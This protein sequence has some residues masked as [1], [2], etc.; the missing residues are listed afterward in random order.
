MTDIAGRLVCTPGAAL[1]QAL[2]STRRAWA[3]VAAPGRAAGDLPAL[4]ASL[5]ALCGGAH[6][7]AA[8]LAVRAAR[9]DPQAP[10]TTQHEAL[11]QDTLR[12]HLRR[13]WLDAADRAEG[14]A[15]A[16]PRVL[17]TCPLLRQPA[18]VDDAA[19]QRWLVAH[20]FGQDAAAWLEAWA[21]EA[22]PTA[23]LW[24]TEGRTWPARALAALHHRLDGWSLPVQA[25]PVQDLAAAAPAL[26]AQLQADPDFALQPLWQGR[27][28]ETGPWT[29]SAE[30]AL[31]PNRAEEFAPAWMRAAARVA[32][33]ARLMAPDDPQAL[34]AGSVALEAGLG[35]A[36]CE[37]ARG[38]LI[39]VVQ[40]DGQDRVRACHVLAPTEWN[41][42][43]AGGL[44]RAL[45]AADPRT[46]PARIGA[47]INAFDP[48]VGVDLER[49]DA[50]A[51]RAAHA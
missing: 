17:G 19:V 43:P 6:R 48:C 49:D 10:D 33:V 8:E 23:Q 13:W 1:G 30:L 47:L 32:D 4:L 5:F 38:L 18:P 3:S 27:T 31:A 7:V 39:H 35:L 15:E 20:V 44:A 24:S 14:D 42:H 29:R 16:D 26:A 51:Q 9:G 40:L 34:A 2:R 36:W 50:A 28:T 22:Q 11:R 45:S 46:P 12:E 37:M 41:F 25:L 21:A